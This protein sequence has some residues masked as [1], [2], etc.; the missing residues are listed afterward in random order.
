MLL[1]IYVPQITLQ[2]ALKVAGP[3]ARLL[4]VSENVKQM[5]VN[6]CHLSYGCEIC[7]I[8]KIVFFLFPQVEK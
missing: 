5:I 7:E 8:S 3:P 6:D 4:V 2:S 1:K